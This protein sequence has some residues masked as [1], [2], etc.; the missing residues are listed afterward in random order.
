[1]ALEQ[2]FEQN[3]EDLKQVYDV[4]IR[5]KTELTQHV[6]DIRTE[7]TKQALGIDGTEKRMEKQIADCQFWM[8]NYTNAYKQSD[9]R[10]GVMESGIQGKMDTINRDL[11]KRVTVD[12]MT[13]NFEKLNEILLIK[14]N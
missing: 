10:M 1:M 11:N 13:K 5:T 14:F 6:A 7:M 12:D 9:A 8:E 4:M 2:K 3:R